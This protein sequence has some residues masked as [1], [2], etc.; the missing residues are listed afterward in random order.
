MK[1]G[2]TVISQDHGRKGAEPDPL[3]RL[4]IDIR[5]SDIKCECGG[6]GCTG[7]VNEARYC[8]FSCGRNDRFRL[9]YI[10]RCGVL[11]CT[12]SSCSAG[13][14]FHIAASHQAEVAQ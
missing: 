8:C 14:T 1:T 3:T 10:R 4:E 12:C 11:Y 2:A 5:L 13:Y 9:E 7:R 6:P